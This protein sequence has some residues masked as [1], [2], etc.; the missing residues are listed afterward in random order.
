MIVNDALDFDKDTPR[1]D[2]GLGL[3]VFPDDGLVSDFHSSKLAFEVLVFNLDHRRRAGSLVNLFQVRDRDLD[4]DA[5]GVEAG[6]A[7]ELLHDADAGSVF[8]H[9]GRAPVAQKVATSGP[10]D[11]GRFDCFGNPVTKVAG[12]DS[13]LE[14]RL[15]KERPDHRQPPR[16]SSE[17]EAWRA[18]FKNNPGE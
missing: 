3:P 4:V 1:N 12:A 11:P 18:S 14:R 7:E 2:G 9:V 13:C 8:V 15:Q 16:K 17:A 10:F 6:V 5:S